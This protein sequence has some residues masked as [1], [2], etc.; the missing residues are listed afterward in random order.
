VA[1][2]IKMNY[3]DKLLQVKI[4]E[5]KLE[6]DTEGTPVI[7]VRVLKGALDKSE[8]NDMMIEVKKQLKI[9]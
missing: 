2:K 4:I 1:T 5:T 7:S 3:K 6:D 9:G 8:I